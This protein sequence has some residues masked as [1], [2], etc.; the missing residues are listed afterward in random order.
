MLKYKHI[1]C[2]VFRNIVLQPTYRPYIY[3]PEFRIEGSSLGL[4]FGKVEFGVVLRFSVRR[5]GR[6][7]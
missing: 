6:A 4:G 1:S 5:M 3:G 7:R 2:Y